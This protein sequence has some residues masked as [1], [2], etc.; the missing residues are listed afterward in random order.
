M[1]NATIKFVSLVVPVVNQP[2]FHR[3]SFHSN[4]IEMFMLVSIT[5]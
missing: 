2:K 1:K 3:K 5:L 4:D